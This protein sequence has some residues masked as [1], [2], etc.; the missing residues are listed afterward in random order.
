MTHAARVRILLASRA[1]PA[2][3]QELRTTP[4]RGLSQARV[5]GES[6]SLAPQE[7]C[8]KKA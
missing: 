6:R 7:P 4:L 8:G 1:S 2:A 3:K 5:G